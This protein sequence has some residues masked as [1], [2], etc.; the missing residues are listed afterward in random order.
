MEEFVRQYGLWAVYFGMWL[1]GETI[2]V[3]AGF[4]A[5]QGLLNRWEVLPVAILGA[6]SVDHL[7]FFAGR[8]ASRFQWLQ[9]VMGH[10]QDP[11]TWKSRLGDSWAV[12]LM[13]RF[14]YGARTPYMFYVGTRK[15]PWPRFFA[16]E[17]APVVLWC[18]LWLFFGHAVGRMLV[19]LCGTLHDHERAWT[20]LGIGTVALAFFGAFAVLRHRRLK[21][22]RPPLSC[23]E[24]LVSGES[25]EPEP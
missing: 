23:G 17:I 20:M 6:L 2:L 21:K 12:F 19:L 10:E 8:H 24:E 1:E 9:R 5:S 25:Q 16:R 14:I 11:G 4:V 3:M 15:L 22:P 13:I 7:V 18:T